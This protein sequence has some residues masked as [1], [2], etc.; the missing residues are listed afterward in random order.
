MFTRYVWLIKTIR[1]SSVNYGSGSNKI[2]VTTSTIK[3]LPK[4][5]N[6]VLV[7]H[8]TNQAYYYNT[9]NNNQKVAMQCK[10]IESSDKSVII[11]IM[12]I[13]FWYGACNWEGGYIRFDHLT[14]CNIC[15]LINVLFLPPPNDLKQTAQSSWM[16]LN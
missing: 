1:M 11:C 3:N 2:I 12:W 4:R 16:V 15:K 8:K 13:S 10:P 7:E 5:R 14:L 9:K 6:L